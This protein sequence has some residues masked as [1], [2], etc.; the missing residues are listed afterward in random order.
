VAEV[1]EFDR[2]FLGYNVEHWIMSLRGRILVRLGFFD[3]ARRCFDRILAIDPALIDPTVQFIAN[4]GYVDLAWY[5]GDATLASTHAKRIVD[6]AT[7]QASP[8]LRAYSLACMGIAYGVAEDYQA[9]IQ[10]LSEGIDLVRAARVAMEIEPEI[11]ASVAE[12]QLRSG[13]RVAAIET[14]REAITIAQ[15]RHARLPECRATITLSAA[16]AASDNPDEL[17]E[18]AI[19]IDRA[20]ALIKLTGASIYRRLLEETRLRLSVGQ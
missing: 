13:A 18:V 19:L 2:Q 14:A 11:L 16:H 12:Y 20:E 4:L 15:Y 3:E 9:A 6:L 7:H 8:Y 5:L 17:R 10:S 1:D